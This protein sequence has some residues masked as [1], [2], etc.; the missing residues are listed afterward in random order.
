MVDCQR[1]CGQWRVYYLSK[2]GRR[3]CFPAAWTDWGAADPFVEQS[4]G[5]AIAR[6]QDLLELAQLVV[7]NVKGITPNV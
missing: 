2:S 5:R 6:V 4:R 3:T 1:Q 7:R